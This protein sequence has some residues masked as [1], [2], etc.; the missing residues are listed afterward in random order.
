M[1]D[2]E[3]VD[4]EPVWLLLLFNSKKSKSDRPIMSSVVWVVSSFVVEFNAEL[5]FRV[6][7]EAK[8]V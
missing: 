7:D 6:V 4:V 1:D 5:A 3:A 8:L 2:D